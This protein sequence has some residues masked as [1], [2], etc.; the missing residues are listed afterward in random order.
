MAARHCTVLGGGAAGLAVAH[1]ARRAGLPCT[2]FEAAGHLGG[3]ARTLVAN[4]AAGEFRYDTGAHRFHTIDPEAAAEMQGLLGGELSRVTA[5]S[6]I[7]YRGHFLDFPLRGGNL[8]EAL[9]LPFCL[10]A[11]AELGRA[12]LFP[13]G[14]GRDFASVALRRYG[15]AIARPFLLDY[16]EKLYGRPAARLSPAIAGRRLDGLHLG[17]FL[18]ELVLG[19]GEGGGT[20]EGAFLYPKEGIGRIA[21]ALAESAGRDRL[22]TGAPVTR[23]RHN[24][25]RVTAV[26]VGGRER[27]VDAATGQVVS[28][29]PLGVLLE[30]LDPLPAGPMLAAARS[31]RFRD[32][33]LVAIF[34]NRDS[35]TGNATVYFPG[36]EFPFTRVCEP[37]NRSFRMAPPGMTSLVAEIPAESGAPCAEP[38]S[39]SVSPP[40]PGDESWL[41]CTLD[42]LESI[43]WVRKGEVLGTAVHRMRRAYPVVEVGVETSVEEVLAWISRLGNLR[44]AGRVGS[45]AYTHLHDQLRAGRDLVAELTLGHPGI[46]RS[47]EP[48]V[49]DLPTRI[50]DIGPAASPEAWAVPRV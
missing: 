22:H 34:L 17:R 14:D 28:T 50:A 42:A 39:G 24:G 21:E 20:W 49:E 23:L 9:G 3:N 19:P 36:A 2:L 5:P 29:L 40:P 32:V 16:T 46:F 12:R 31:L 13:S 35:V 44:T 4:L 26:E 27:P 8:V 45:F 18:R 47:D 6:E 33:I 1:F 38:L 11:G 30:L 25:V 48:P 37:R 15:P 41:R 7:Y 43:G 10:R